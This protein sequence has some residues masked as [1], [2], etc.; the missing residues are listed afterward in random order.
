M[1]YKLIYGGNPIKTIGVLDPDGK[2][3][4]PLTSQPYQ[5]I[6]YDSEKEKNEYNDTYQGFAKFWSNLPMYKQK[7]KEILDALEKSQ[8]VL[9]TA[10]TGAG[11]TVLL[12]KYLMHIFNYT[13]KIAV[14]NPKR[15]PSEE[16]AKFA[17]LHFDVKLGEQVGFRYRGKK[18]ANDQ[19]NLLY[20]TDGYLV[21]KLK[22]ESLL[23]SRFRC[24]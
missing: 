4:N 1:K 2:S 3:D 7:T 17:A 23:T 8:V 19:T 22:G 14:T 5:N 24:G 20:C 10:G 15:I 12:P 11:K 21:A 9:I 16:N 18:M 13:S 6:H